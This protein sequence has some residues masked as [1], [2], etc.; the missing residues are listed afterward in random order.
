MY[1]IYTK[2]ILDH[3]LSIIQRAC[4]ARIIIYNITNCIVENFI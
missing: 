4:I 1:W 2:F 3:L